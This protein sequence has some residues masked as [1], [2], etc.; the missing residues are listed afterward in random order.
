MNLLQVVLALFSSQILL[1]IH[2]NIYEPRKFKT[3]YNFEQRE[4]KIIMDC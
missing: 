3:T 2:N 4:Y 1:Y